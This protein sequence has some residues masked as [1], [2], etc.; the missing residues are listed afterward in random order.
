MNKSY[1]KKYT[2]VYDN[3][4]I[5]KWY[6]DEKIVTDIFIIGEVKSYMG[7][8]APSGWLL[9]NG[10]TISRNKY[11]NLF[12]VIDTQYGSGD[13]VSTFELPTI[14][15]SDSVLGYKIIKY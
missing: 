3:D 7:A 9:C 12:N 14:V 6:F 10:D 13:G 2:P 5:Q 8:S 15:D 11:K 1:D 4:L